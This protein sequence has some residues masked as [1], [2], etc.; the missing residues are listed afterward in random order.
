VLTLPVES[1]VDNLQHLG[2][3]ADV[4]TEAVHFASTTIDSRHFAS[5]FIRLHKQAEKGIAPE[6]SGAPPSATGGATT[7]NGGAAAG[8][9]GWSEV[10]KK[11]GSSSSQADRDASNGNFRVVQGKRRD[12]RR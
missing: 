9:G 3:D 6:P 4:L 10:A 1:F 2:L 5:E 8:N 11:G 7:I 12:R